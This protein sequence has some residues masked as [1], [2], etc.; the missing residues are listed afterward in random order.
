MDGA[1]ITLESFAFDFAG[2][3]WNSFYVS[4]HGALTFGGPLTYA[5][6]DARQ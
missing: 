6:R 3:R 1:V 2:R 5:Y 4:R